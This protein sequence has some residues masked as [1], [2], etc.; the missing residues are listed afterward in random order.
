MLTYKKGDLLEAEERY[1]AHGCNAQGVMGSGVAK[2]LRDKWPEVFN[3][4]RRL[5][6]VAGLDLGF[7]QGVL[8]EN[9]KTVLNA[10][11]QDR[12]GTDRRH[13]DYEAIAKCFGNINSLIS[14]LEDPEHRVV[15]IPM[16]GAGLAGGDWM[17][18]EQIIVSETPDI[19]V[20][21]YQLEG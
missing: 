12:Y 5:Y 20:V 3:Q 6:E 17:V 18:I 14:G 2:A 7:V 16:I 15:A 19:D 9:N 4:Y 1:I 21:V 11:T 13:A 8:V 10:I